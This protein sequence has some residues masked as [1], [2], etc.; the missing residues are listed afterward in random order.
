MKLLR[1]GEQGLEK[2]A[3]TLDN[4]IYSLANYCE[5]FDESFFAN[6]GLSLLKQY[7][8]TK[9]ELVPVSLDVRIGS[10][11][12]RPSKIVGIGLNYLDH[13]LST[14]EAIPT[15]PVLF[16]KATSALCGPFDPLILP[17]GSKKTDWEVELA[18]II[19]AKAR[20]VSLDDAEKCIAGYALI[21][22]LSE[23]SYQMEGGGTVDKGKGCDTFAPLGPYL[24]TDENDLNVNNLR[25]WLRVNGKLMQDSNT[26]K[27]I[28]K[29]PFLI[30]YISNYMT[31]LPGDVI[32][33]GTPLGTGYRQHPQLFLSS[34]DSVEAGI[35][36][37][38]E[39]K[40]SCVN[41]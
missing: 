12:P 8:A 21:N 11:I 32:A 39:S 16:L 36:M 40:Q 34:G 6:N 24:V 18:V 31:L 3:I 41:A 9:P 30:S 2:P 37:L 20:Y 33:T 1:Y 25:I 13:A 19:G 38:G 17:K 5:D 28:F 10:C 27:L 29:I 22:D 23:R 7:L 15:E 35:D 14:G 4:K 26:S